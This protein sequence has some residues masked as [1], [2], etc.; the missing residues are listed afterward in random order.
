L[1]IY[2]DRFEIFSSLSTECLKAFATKNNGELP[3]RIIFYR[4]GVGQ[5]DLACVHGT[6]LTQL[7][8]IIDGL[9]EN[10]PKHKKVGFTFIVVTK[11]G[12]ARIM[13]EAGNGNPP[14]GTVVDSVITIPER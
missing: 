6:E 5:G 8:A 2:F 10:T 3:D 11:K 9:Y 13:L 1:L 4:D 7:E 14:P 12:N